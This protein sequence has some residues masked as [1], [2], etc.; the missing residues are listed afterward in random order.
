MGDPNLR[1]SDAERSQVADALSKHFSEG[2]L[3]QTE[4][5]QRLHQAMSAKTRGD[6][7]GLLADL[8][9]FA[10]PSGP[11]FVHRRRRLGLLLLAVFVF[12]AALGSTVDWAWDGHWHVPWLLVAVVLFLLWR[13]SH[14]RRHRHSHW[15]GGWNGPAPPSSADAPPWAYH[16]RGW[17]V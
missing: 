3:D 11:P 10:P 8:P 1:V 13:R 2:R 14:W 16:R 12:F 5:D 4:F 7:S 9:P 6:L 15:P 17:W